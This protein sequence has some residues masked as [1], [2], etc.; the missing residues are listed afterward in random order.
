MFLF[1]TTTVFSQTVSE[2][3]KQKSELETQINYTTSL[4]NTISSDKKKSITYL[5]IWNTQIAQKEQYVISLNREISQ[6]NNKINEIKQEEVKTNNT[7]ELN[8]KELK[9]AKDENE[10]MINAA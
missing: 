4:L 5:N 7:I 6:L 10:K 3:E 8:Q 9:T 2:L 1:F